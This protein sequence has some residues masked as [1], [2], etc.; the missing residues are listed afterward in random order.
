[1]KN[2]NYNFC[3]F[4]RLNYDD[5]ATANI[6]DFYAGI[7]VKKKLFVPKLRKKYKIKPVVKNGMI[8]GFEI[9]APYWFVSQLLK[10]FQYKPIIDEEYILSNC[11]G[12]EN[13]YVYKEEWE[14]PCMPKTNNIFKGE[15][16]YVK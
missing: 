7:I 11:I 9:K 16:R 15:K 13:G 12:F 4:F 8:Q 1:M 10:R 2:F 3:N 14:N 5:M 6:D